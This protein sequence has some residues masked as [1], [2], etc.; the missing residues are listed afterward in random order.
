M[1]H[2]EVNPFMALEAERLIKLS[3]LIKLLR[4]KAEQAQYESK[5]VPNIAI[6]LH[7]ST[8]TDMDIPWQEH[9]EKRPDEFLAAMNDYS[10]GWNLIALKMADES[11]IEAAIQGR[12]TPDASKFWTG[13][14]M[15][16]LLT[17]AVCAAVIV[18]HFL[19][20]G[21]VPLL[22]TTANLKPALMNERA[23]AGFVISAL[24]AALGYQKRQAPKPVQALERQHAFLKTRQ[25][26]NTLGIWKLSAQKIH[27]E[28]RKNTSSLCDRSDIAPLN[29]DDALE[30][31]ILGRMIEDY[32]GSLFP[33][34]VLKEQIQQWVELKFPV[35]IKN[36][37]F[38]PNKVGVNE[39]DEKG[40]FSFRNKKP[41]VANLSLQIYRFFNAQHKD[42]LVNNEYSIC[43]SAIGAE[44]STS[45]RLRNWV[46]GG[47]S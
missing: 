30:E 46:N 13:L 37:T 38:K 33:N 4:W 35:E 2:A 24:A 9:L 12:M 16:S 47:Q 15:V 43:R 45:S 20:I 44:S 39:L 10:I 14:M 6:M 17:L 8:M 27:D 21:K 25:V 18:G 41:T 3:V 36:P 28:E 19:G 34:D 23:C 32:N 1:A 42:K 11:L 29:S 40:T 22:I 5:R 26:D 31:M 7:V